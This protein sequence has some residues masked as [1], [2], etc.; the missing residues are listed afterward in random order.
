MAKLELQI[1]G[2]ND[3]L[4]YLQING[5]KQKLTTNPDK[6][7][8]CVFEGE[9]AEITIYKPHN[10]VGKNWFWWSLLFYFISIFGIFDV[11][12][13]K[14]CLMVDCRFKVTLE[15][16][17]KVVLALNKF[18]D[19]GK[20]AEIQTEEAVEETSNIQFYDKVAQKRHKKMKWAK[21]GIS[22]LTL[23]LVAVIITLKII[24]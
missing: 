21:F 4:D 14:R 16:D 10:Y 13:N 3:A 9:N 15:K 11:K 20:F 1:V 23:I 6:T 5:K 24:N 18:E 19:G 7:R 12:Q 22:F 8:T 17:K 2:Y